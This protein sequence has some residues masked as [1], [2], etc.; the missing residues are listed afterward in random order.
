MKRNMIR[1]KPMLDAARDES[2]VVCG[3]RDGTVVAAHYTGMRAHALGKGTGCK[4]HDLFIADLCHRC[5]TKFDQH[6]KSIDRSTSTDAFFRKVDVSEQFAYAILQTL[7]RRVG[8]GVITIKG[9]KPN[10]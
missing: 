10:D 4:P 3:A 2:C 7:I 9:H 5:H 1:S 6:D 8:Q